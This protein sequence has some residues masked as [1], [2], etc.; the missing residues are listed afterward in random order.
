MLGVA[1]ARSQIVSYVDEHGKRVYINADKP[2]PRSSRV[3]VRAAAVGPSPVSEAEPAKESASTLWNPRVARRVPRE[4]LERL[5]H[6]TAERHRVDPAL[7]R[8]VIETESNWDPAAVSRRGALGLMQLVPGT[9]RRFG[10]FD[11]LNPQQNL[12]A[13][14]RYLR[15]L[16]ERYKGDLNLSLAAY[17]AG[18]GA[19]DRARGVPNIRETRN[20]VQKVTDSYFR[21]GSGRG[22]NGWS[23]GRPIYRTTDDRGRVL[24]TNE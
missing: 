5:V 20:Y 17:N 15:A 21:P 13:G 7:V 8:A 9:A 10:V 24:F 22:P 14:V 18:E 2:M 16:L 4:G 19:V 12:D 1:P 6:E 23:A 11:I 3:V